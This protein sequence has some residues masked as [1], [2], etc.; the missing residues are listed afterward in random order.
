MKRIIIAISALSFLTS[1]C[2]ST[3]EV[4]GNIDIYEDF[5]SQL[6]ASRTVRVW[7]P[8]DYDPHRKYDVI[9]MHDGQNLFNA[10]I[11]WNG[12]EWGVDE[13]MT[14]LMSEGRIRP[15]IVVGIDCGSLRYEEYYPSKICGNIS[16]GTLP[17]GFTPLG[18]E[19]LRF[20][21]E[22]VKPFIDGRYST[23]GDAAHTFVSGSSCGGLISSYALCEYPEV[24]SGAAC[25]STHSNMWNPHTDADQTPAADAYREYLRQNL[26]ADQDHKLYMDCGD[27]TIDAGYDKTQKAI[28]DMILTLNWTTE[29]GSKGYL[30]RFF[31]GHAHMETDWNARFEE[32]VLFLLSTGPAASQQ[33]VAPMEQ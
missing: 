15:C 6:V 5:D 2:T 14:R 17:E 31:P 10:S 11:T 32:P 24:F 22:E 12:Q 4:T 29:D 21:V 8:A 18:D 20:I 33:A 9:Y 16:E 7:T 19:Y 3:P 25:L 13:T 23:W 28:N 26:P 27:K 1:A 30:Y